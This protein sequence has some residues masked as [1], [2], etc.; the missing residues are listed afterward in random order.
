M[1]IDRLD[2]SFQRIIMEVHYD[3]GRLVTRDEI[4]S[5]DV[6]N[7]WNVQINDGSG[8]GLASIS[9]GIDRVE[10]ERGIWRMNISAYPED[11]V[12]TI[13]LTPA[14]MNMD[15]GETHRNEENSIVIR[16]EK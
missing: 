13:T 6:P 5:L 16:I 4:M 8:G 9:T 3:F 14:E 2:V 12:K 15:T 10:G 7:W 1:V 11:A